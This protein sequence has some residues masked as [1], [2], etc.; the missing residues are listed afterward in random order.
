MS[1][2]RKVFFI[3][4]FALVW[5]LGAGTVIYRS[6]PGIP[7]ECSDTLR[8]FD[9]FLKE[10]FLK[11]PYS[12]GVL[13]IEITGTASP[14]RVLSKE[15]FLVNRAELERMELKLLAE[16]GGAILHARGKAPE[17]FVLPYF[18]CG[19]FRHRERSTAAE[20]RFLGNNRK[21]RSVTALLRS[22]ARPPLKELLD[23]NAPGNSPIEEEWFDDSSR[24]IL[25]LIRRQGIRCTVEQLASEAEKCVD[26][27]SSVEDLVPFIWNNFN[28]LPPE[29]V[30]LELDTMLKV[31]IPPIPENPLPAPRKK[32]SPSKVKKLIIPQGASALPKKSYIQ[33]KPAPQKSEA[34]PKETPGEPPEKTSEAAPEKK[35]SE[36]VHASLLPQ[37]LRQHPLRDQVCRE[38]A[39]AVMS[40]SGRLPAPLRP[41]LRQLHDAA[42]QL[43]RNDSAA[44]LFAES[45]SK[46]EKSCELH[47]ARARF[48]DEEEKAAPC[49]KL[50]YRYPLRTN[51]LSGELLSPEG[52]LFLEHAES[53]YSGI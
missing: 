19:A 3:L 4:F 29:L 15:E 11:S 7:L 25:E 49:Q 32:E 28:P 18:L 21:L 9:R 12:K 40:R 1:A 41:A 36:T 37:K 39:R 44:A 47:K 46:L 35:S 27:S 52:R 8:R 43:G 31:E 10:H 38:F 45:L 53:A 42:L 16:V 30:R 2:V 26:S 17:K 20:G 50:L 34:V 24:L 5:D 23:L 22:G 13:T 33:K 48:L 6:K 51:S 14:S